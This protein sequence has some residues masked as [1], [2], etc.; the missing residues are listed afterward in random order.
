MMRTVEVLLVIVILTGAYIAVSTFAVLPT[1]TQVSSTTLNML[2]LTTLQELDSQYDLSSAVFQTNNNT[3]WGGLQVALSASLPPNVLYNLTVYNVNTLSNGAPLYSIIANFSNA[4]TLGV[5]SNA[6]SY[7]VASSNVTYISTPQQIATGGKLVNLYILNCSDTAGWWITG[8]TPA[9]LAQTV[10]SLL[11]PYFNTTVM[12]QN[13]NQLNQILNGQPLQGESLNNSVIINTCGEAVPIPSQFNSTGWDSNN[14]SY[15]LYDYILG[16][17]TQ[18]YN[19]TWV[20]IVGWPFYYVTNTNQT[21]FLANST[22]T[23]GIYGMNMT[24]SYGLTAFLQG[25]DSQSYSYATSSTAQPGVVYLSSQTLSLCNY[26]GLYPSTY[27][28]STRALYASIISQY[29]LT[30]TTPVFNPMNYDGKQW[31]SISMTWNGSQWVLP[32]SGTWNSTECNPGA[33]YRHVSAINASNYNGG[34]YALGMTRIPDIRLAALGILCDY[35]PPRY[36]SLY[37]ATGSNRLVV[38]QLGL[39]GGG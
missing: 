4:A 38:L 30:V 12:I 9:S 14:K 35:Q 29:H 24:G 26:Y 15:A 7:L 27:Q 37:T 20:S 16:Q 6:A 25:L 2:A 18:V 34:L 19:W 32:N 36:S 1:P 22:N 17:D 28:T 10:Y 11:A 5:T 3:I 13:T 21:G 39:A 23:W 33:V 8:Y 31:N